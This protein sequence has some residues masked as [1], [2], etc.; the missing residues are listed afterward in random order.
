M[1]MKSDTFDTMC[2]QQFLEL[3]VRYRF[4]ISHSPCT[5]LKIFCISFLYS[6]IDLLDS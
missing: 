6:E 4:A 1:L 3:P 5:Y 2:G